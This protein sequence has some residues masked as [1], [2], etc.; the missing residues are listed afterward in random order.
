MAELAGR[1]VAGEDRVMD[2]GR[3]CGDAVRSGDHHVDRAAVGGC[4]VHEAH[5]AQF[6]GFGEVA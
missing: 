4:E 5:V 1:G 6:E 3:L 2:A